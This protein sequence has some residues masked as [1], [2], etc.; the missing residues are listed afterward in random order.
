MPEWHVLGPTDNMCSILTLISLA[1]TVL[2]IVVLRCM[3][4]LKP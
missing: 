1:Y 3:F 2:L 4:I